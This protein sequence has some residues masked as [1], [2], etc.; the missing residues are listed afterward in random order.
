MPRGHFTKP[1]ARMLCLMSAL[2]CRLSHEQTSAVLSFACFSK[3]NTIEH[4]L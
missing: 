1:Y 2:H 3:L 4:Y